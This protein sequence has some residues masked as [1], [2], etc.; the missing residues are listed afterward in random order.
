MARSIV[1]PRISLSTLRVAVRHIAE[2]GSAGMKAATLA[3]TKGSPLLAA[4][5]AAEFPFTFCQH[6]GCE[7]PMAHTGS[8]CA[9]A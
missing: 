7:M 5:M 3:A 8:P 1:I 4:A 9:A 2:R 6:E